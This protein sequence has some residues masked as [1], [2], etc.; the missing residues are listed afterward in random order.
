MGK[1]FNLP[2]ATEDSAALQL[3]VELFVPCAEGHLVH[4]TPVGVFKQVAWCF[5]F[6]SVYSS[7]AVNQFAWDSPNLIVNPPASGWLIIRPQPLI[8]FSLS[9]SKCKQSEGNLTGIKQA[10]D[11][12][13]V[14]LNLAFIFLVPW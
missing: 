2:A 14:C 5:S 7:F 4:A 11:I 6:S 9:K 8:P 1:V 13:D 10:G 12:F 3:F